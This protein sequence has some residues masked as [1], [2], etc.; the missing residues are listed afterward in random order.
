[1][2]DDHAFNLETFDGEGILYSAPHN[3]C[4]TR[5]TRVNNWSEI[6]DLL[7]RQPIDQ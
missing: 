7:L 1:M 5:F 6:H 4:E 2:I 3:A